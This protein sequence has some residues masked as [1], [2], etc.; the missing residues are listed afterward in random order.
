MRCAPRSQLLVDN[1]HARPRGPAGLTRLHAALSACYKTINSSAEFRSELGVTRASRISLRNWAASA[2]D[3]T[4]EAPVSTRQTA[5]DVDPDTAIEEDIGSWFARCISVIGCG[6]LV[7]KVC[8][9][10]VPTSVQ[11]LSA[12]T[13]T[14]L[15]SCANAG[16]G[17]LQGTACQF[18]PRAY[19][20]G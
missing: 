9:R 8:T 2:T 13:H 7:S 18:I 20:P 10:S 14:H 5:D 15:T 4:G 11:V 12:R 17:S 1:L 19:R 6:A 3:C 16:A